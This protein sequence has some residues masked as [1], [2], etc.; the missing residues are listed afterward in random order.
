MFMNFE[1]KYEFSAKL[2]LPQKENSFYRPFKIFFQRDNF[3]R[4]CC[5]ALENHKNPNRTNG[6]KLTLT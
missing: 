3:S 5:F 2:M 4:F 6:I 1:I